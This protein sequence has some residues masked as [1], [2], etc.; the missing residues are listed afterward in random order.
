M[1]KTILSP[2]MVA[3]PFGRARPMT[4]AVFLA[5]MDGL[6]KKGPMALFSSG[7]GLLKNQGK[8]VGKALRQERDLTIKAGRKPD[9]CPPAKAAMRSI[10]T[11]RLTS[12]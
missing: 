11:I 7:V 1:K 3:T 8:A 5:K 12:S 4:V 6:Q 10:D 2:I 9:Y